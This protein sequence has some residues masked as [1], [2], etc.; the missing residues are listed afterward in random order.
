MIGYLLSHGIASIAAD[1]LEN[2]I[3]ELHSGLFIKRNAGHLVLI[4][5]DPV[6]AFSGVT[7]FD[8]AILFERVFGIP[9]DARYRAMARDKAEVVWRTGRS[10]R[11]TAMNA[12]HLLRA[13]DPRWAGGIVHNGLFVAYSGVQEMWDEAIA[14]TYAAIVEAMCRE[15]MSVVLGSQDV[16]RLGDELPRDI[17]HFFGGVTFDTA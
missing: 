16:S 13:G 11:D 2:V 3:S 12:P 7:T 6:H 4:N 8:E 1:T 14:Y 15:G 9:E 10:T 17:D 5:P